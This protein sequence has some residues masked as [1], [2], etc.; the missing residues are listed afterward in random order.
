VYLN[1]AGKPKKGIAVILST[2]IKLIKPETTT[3][4]VWN[5]TDGRSI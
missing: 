4:E 2:K 5:F 3:H 1:G